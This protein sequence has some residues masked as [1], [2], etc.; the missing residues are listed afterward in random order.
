[1]LLKKM[2]EVHQK[3]DDELKNTRATLKIVK[4]QIIHCTP[5]SR[6]QKSGIPLIREEMK[7]QKDDE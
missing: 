6:N 4:L 2:K 3:G 7:A 1:M 5:I